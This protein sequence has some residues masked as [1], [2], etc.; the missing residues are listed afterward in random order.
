[1]PRCVICNNEI[2]EGLWICPICETKK[3][4]NQD[5]MVFTRM[6]TPPIPNV[7]LSFSDEKTG[8]PNF[9]I[10]YYRKKRLN[11]LQIW[12]FKVCFGITA[13]NCEGIEL[14]G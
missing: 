5:E 6:Y 11:K 4:F 2:P 13:K 8:A 7:Q 9:L 10:N 12:M 1:M 3:I 14:N